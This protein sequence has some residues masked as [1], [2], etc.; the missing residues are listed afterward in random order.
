VV[1]NCGAEERG[2]SIALR[3]DA[4]HP[5]D[6]TTIAKSSTTNDVTEPLSSFD[7]SSNADRLTL[8]RRHIAAF[9]H[10]DLLLQLELAD[11]HRVH[12]LSSERP[13]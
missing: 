10:S 8:E 12:K 6:S 1:A 7:S 9:C 13:E 3:T 4:G 11:C 2:G 5:H